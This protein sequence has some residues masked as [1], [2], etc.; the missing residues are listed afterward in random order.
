MA[1]RYA[2]IVDDNPDAR[3]ILSVAMGRFGF[4]IGMAS[5]GVE[6][7]ESLEKRIPDIILLDLM[8]PRA[9]GFQV[10][11][12]L[13][14]KPETRDIPVIVISSV[15][16]KELLKIPGVSGVIPKTAFSL[17]ELKATVSNVLAEHGLLED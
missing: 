9:N 4:E 13:R 1:K 12:Q 6:G 10:L 17:K 5:D 14:G 7:L 8:M 2:L 15:S 3:E 16:N 11:R